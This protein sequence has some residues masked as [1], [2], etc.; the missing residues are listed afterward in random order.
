[1]KK[2][3]QESKKGEINRENK[4]GESGGKPD[5]PALLFGPSIYSF[6]FIHYLISYGIY[7]N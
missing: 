6:V 7:N 3:K 5:Y 1:M 4:E 2:G